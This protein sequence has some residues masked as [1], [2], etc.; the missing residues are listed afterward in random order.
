MRQFD[1]WRSET[2]E[3]INKREDA[4]RQID[5]WRSET[6]ER[7]NKRE[8]AVRQ[9]D[10]WRSETCERINKRGDVVL[11]I[12]ACSCRCV[13]KDINE[14]VLQIEEILKVPETPTLRDKLEKLGENLAVPGREIKSK[15]FDSPRSLST[16]DLHGS[17]D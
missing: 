17:V 5:H 10:H 3:R 16:A 13:V 4:V 2:C 7:I 6:C 15:V 14:P 11:R 12:A 9:I 1:H 8:D